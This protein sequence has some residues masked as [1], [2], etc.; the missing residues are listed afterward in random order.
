[1]KKR[2][3]KTTALVL[4]GLLAFQGSIT[5]ALA[6]ENIPPET[7]HEEVVDDTARRSQWISDFSDYG[8]GSP[9]DYTYVESDS[10]SVNVYP[11]AG[12]ITLTALE[13]AV[14]LSLSYFASPI[15]SF[16]YGKIISWLPPLALSAFEEYAPNGG[17][18][19]F[20]Y[21]KYKNEEISNTSNQYFYYEVEYFVDGHSVTDEPIT[22]YETRTLI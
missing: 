12:R 18:M 7:T 11:S 13:D 19:E 20:T 17:P 4:C 8:P 15:A 14:A 10:G 16:L 21:T 5:P 2:L 6:S 1:M 3:L 22:F 9:D